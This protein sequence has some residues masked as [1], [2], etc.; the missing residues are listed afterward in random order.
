[1]F[2]FALVA[3]VTSFVLRR[4]RFGRYVYAIGGNAEAA[5]RTGI[6]VPRIT[7]LV[8]VVGGVYAALAGLILAARLSA[9]I[10]AEGVAAELD[11]ITAV[12]I[13]GTSFTGGVGTIGGTVVGAFIIGFISNSLTINGI[14]ANWQLIVKGLIMIFAVA[15]DQ[16]GK[17]T[18]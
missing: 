4:T 2:I 12:V 8:F 13:G 5:R 11:A 17:R 16:Y 15:L 1:M 14:D 10:P 3:V 6:N 7:R 18:T 9:G